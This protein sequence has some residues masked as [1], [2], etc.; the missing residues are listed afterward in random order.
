[1]MYRAT[2][3]RS[4]VLSLSMGWTISTAE[5]KVEDEALT[6]RICWVESWAAG[7]DEPHP[8]MANVQGDVEFKVPCIT[9]AT[10]C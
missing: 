6:A 5:E 8:N 7:D 2:I 10:F 1:M 3:A 4:G 9:L